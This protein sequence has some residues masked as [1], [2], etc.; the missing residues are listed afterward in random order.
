VIQLYLRL[1][2]T[3]RWLGLF[4][5]LVGLSTVWMIWNLDTLAGTLGNGRLVNLGFSLACMAV[6]WGGAG[7]RLQIDDSP[8]FDRLC[9]GIIRQLPLLMLS[10]TAV[11]IGLLVL[12]E[13]LS[14][15]ARA[16]LLA[17]AMVGVL[18][19]P[20][21]QA[22]LLGERDRLLAAERGL[23][24]SR[25]RLE[26]LAHHDALTGLGN[27]TRLRTRVEAAI[28]AADRSGH[29]AAL[30]FIDLDQFKEV[31]DTLGHGTGDALLEHTARQ[32]ES[33][34]RG[35]DTV[36]RHGGDEF[37]IVLPGVRGVSE[38][39]RVM[40]KIMAVAGCNARVNGHELPMSMS[41]GAAFYPHD[42]RDFEG[43]L[44]CA[45]IAMYQAKA[46][47]RNAYRFYEA[48]MS[49]EASDRAQLRGRLARAVERG[50]LALHYQPIVQ[51]GSRR[52]VGAEALLRWQHPELGMVAP[53][54]FIPVAEK[55]GLIV[56]IGAWVLQEACRQAAQWH[57]AGLGH[58]SVAVNLS[59][60]QF[61]RGNLEKVVLDA[62][63]ASGLPHR[64][65]E[66]EV[67][68][69]VLV[70]QHDE[71]VTTLER[72]RRFGI[73]VAI[74]D[75]GTGYCNI[76]YLKRLPATKL[77][78]DQS[79]TR[80]IA[81]SPRDASIARTIIQ[82][83]HELE[84]ATVAEGVETDPQCQVLQ[85]LGCDQ[86]QGYLFSRAVPGEAFAAL[87]ASERSA[88]GEMLSA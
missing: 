82:L 45:D 25:A 7:W 59:V 61:R 60:L 17:L 53:S 73:R 68:E 34:V 58:L 2:W 35:S 11:S 57:A 65:L 46:A 41:I 87:C 8:R 20:L 5:G 3:A 14:V 1:R 21:R 44:Q 32:L 39:V 13:H 80:E 4:T 64:F 27:L 79:L 84:L 81:G 52:I 10:M 40:D 37:A 55:S 19:A 30:L 78:M 43:L 66:L 86:A 51:L 72:L 18:F 42:A 49:A 47:G 24:E 77:K 71:L 85:G 26:Y 12:D 50:E 48:Q 69:S 29:G 38:V 23:A 9:E 75:F 88:G 31:N 63:Q 70:E 22:M 6:G 54:S 74:D 76:A 62:L 83:A 56:P 33:I 67:T 15:A 28:T 16:I 36:C